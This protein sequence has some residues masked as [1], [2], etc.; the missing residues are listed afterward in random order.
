MYRGSGPTSKDLLLNPKDLDFF[1][2]L[3]IYIM[4]TNNGS[5]VR[6]CWYHHQCAIRSQVFLPLLCSDLP[7]DPQ[8]TVL[9]AEFGLSRIL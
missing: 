1:R 7:T 6:M 3:F 8:D 2:I 4:I 9:Q 5:F